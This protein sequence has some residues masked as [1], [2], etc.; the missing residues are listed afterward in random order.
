MPVATEEES[1]K[2]A[3]GAEGG[4]LASEAGL[5]RCFLY[6]VAVTP[7]ACRDPAVPSWVLAPAAL[8]VEQLVAAVPSWALAPVALFC[9]PVTAVLFRD[10]VVPYQHL[11]A[12]V[13]DCPG[14]PLPLA[15]LHRT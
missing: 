12:F 6:Q 8:F 9:V 2:E 15:H 1:G 11:G 3:P 10:P 13:A 4:F 7:A 5:E 14:K